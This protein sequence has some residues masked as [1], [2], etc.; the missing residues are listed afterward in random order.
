MKIRV[1]HSSAGPGWLTTEH[2]A[3]SY[4]QPVLVLDGQAYG[5]GDEIPAPNSGTWAGSGLRTTIAHS[6]LHRD[7]THTYTAE[8]LAWVDE[9]IIRD[10]VE[11]V[12][13]GT[14]WKFGASFKT[15]SQLAEI[16]RRI[17]K[18]VPLA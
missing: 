18:R 14:S 8:E 4:G 15:A 11:R 7:R 16:E 2:V 10:H 12:P 1:C 13:Y 6:Y 17:G 5:P 3:S 9:Y